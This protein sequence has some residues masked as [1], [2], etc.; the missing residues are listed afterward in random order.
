MALL[1]TPSREIHSQNMVGYGHSACTHPNNYTLMVE[2]REDGLGSVI[3]FESKF[4]AVNIGYGL[5]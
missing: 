5:G 2:Y 4:S 1:F 3:Q